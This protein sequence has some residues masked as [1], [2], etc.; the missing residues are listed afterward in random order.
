MSAPEI[1]IPGVLRADGTLELSRKPELAAGPVEV[2]LRPLATV[3]ADTPTEDWFRPVREAQEKLLAG[4]HVFRTAAEV[5]ADRDHFRQEVEERFQEIERIQ[6]E[7]RR[8]REQ[9][10]C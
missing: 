10:G 3:A 5:A 8:A 9:A 2:V 1:V 4:G 6:D 7:S